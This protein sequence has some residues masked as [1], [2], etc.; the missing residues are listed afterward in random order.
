MFNMWHLLK[1]Q[2]QSL[3][4]RNT[5]RFIRSKKGQMTFLMLLIP[6]LLF[7]YISCVYTISMMMILPSSDKMLAL[8]LM[9]LFS[10]FFMIILSFDGA[11]GHLFG[12]KDYELLA[13]LPFRQGE[14]LTAKLLSFLILQYFY[15]AILYL[16]AL[17][18]V[19][20]Y[21]HQPFDYYLLGVTASL[22]VPMLPIVVASLI[23]MIVSYVA[24]KFTH[25]KLI[26]NLMLLVMSV[27]LIAGLIAYQILLSKDVASFEA[28]KQNLYWFAPFVMFLMRGVYEQNLWYYFLGICINLIPFILFIYLFAKSY[29][30]INESLKKGYHVKNFKLSA[31][32]ASTKQVALLKKE[33]QRYFSSGIYMM[34][35]AFGVIIEL[36]GAVYLLFNPDVLNV[37]VTSESGLS[38]EGMLLIGMV[39]VSLFTCTTQV[40]ISLEGKQFWLLKT[41]P[42]SAKD[43]F[44]SKMAVTWL[45][46]IPLGCVSLLLFA[47]VLKMNITMLIMGL[48]LIIV[49]SVFISMAGLIINLHYPRL[50]W[51][52]EAHIIK[53]S[54]AS[55]IAAFGA[56]LMGIALFAFYQYISHY[57]GD[58]AAMALILGGFVCLS[59]IEMVY[60]NR[61]G[62]KLLDQIS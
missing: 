42:V 5:S 15:V 30:Q 43:I 18:I 12:S 26:R 6:I 9:T 45:V 60:L 58:L 19:G 50:D 25:Q 47:Y 37:L 40:S 27:L 22:F 59:V 51:D 38:L 2:V 28:I 53:Q 1:I 49:S 29:R 11:Q 13:A 35:T 39:F 21:L 8:P 32:K 62:T 17:F 55:M 48:L 23:A 4:A 33:I 52:N 46:S 3:F 14:I 36:F 20:I 44:L 10:M 31:S 16:P 41:L 34:N 61:R 54:M 24:S 56:I 57:I 7:L